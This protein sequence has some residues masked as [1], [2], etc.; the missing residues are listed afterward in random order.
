MAKVYH[1]HSSYQ[2]DAGY[3]GAPNFTYQRYCSKPLNLLVSSA[4]LKGYLGPVK[5]GK[6]RET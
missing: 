2:P 5:F 4:K 6:G 1:T 3:H